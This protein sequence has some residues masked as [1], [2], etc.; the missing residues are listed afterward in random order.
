MSH[1]EQDGRTIESITS[2]NRV[3]QSLLADIEMSIIFD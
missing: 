2:A 3:C 1:P